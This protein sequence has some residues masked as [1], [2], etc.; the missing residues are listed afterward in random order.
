[1]PNNFEWVL[2]QLEG[3]ASEDCLCTQ[4][5]YNVCRSC[6]AGGTL[7]RISADAFDSLEELGDE[8]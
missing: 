4:N 6:K 8:K 5:D 2:A 1:M 7:N 3:I